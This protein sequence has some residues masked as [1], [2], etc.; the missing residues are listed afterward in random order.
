MLIYYSCVDSDGEPISCSD[1]MS[2]KSDFAHCVI[3][4]KNGDL[5]TT[6]AYPG[7]PA[8]ATLPD[9]TPSSN[10]GLPDALVKTF[11]NGVISW[12]GAAGLLQPAVCLGYA[13]AMANGDPAK[14]AV[15]GAI[16]ICDTLTAVSSIQLAVA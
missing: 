5:G 9:G 4:T 8:P 15:E 1:C 2:A 12:L 6:T 16:N 7:D 13:Y 10:M 14:T 3:T 11:C